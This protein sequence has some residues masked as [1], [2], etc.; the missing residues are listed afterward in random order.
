[1]KRMVLVL[2]LA[3]LVGGVA[4]WGQEINSEADYW[5]SLD[6]K[7]KQSSLIYFIM[8]WQQST[9]IVYGQ[10]HDDIEDGREVL[11]KLFQK[12]NTPS[13]ID[14]LIP[15][16]DSFFTNP[17]NKDATLGQAIAAYQLSLPKQL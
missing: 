11:N 16:V 5:L 1:M 6:Y 14:K 7:S 12:F 15:Y 10:F 9:E 17:E 13:A 2:V 3:G 8:A 4:A